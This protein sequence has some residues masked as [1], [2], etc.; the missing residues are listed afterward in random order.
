V[1][2]LFQASA[3]GYTH[4]VWN[5]T[6]PWWEFIVRGAIVYVFLIVLLRLTGKR[7]VGQLAPFDLVLLL[8]LSNAV[9]NSNRLARSTQATLRGRQQDR[10]QRIPPH[11]RPGRVTIGAPGFGILVNSNRQEA[12]KDSASLGRRCGDGRIAASVVV[13]RQ[14]PISRVLPFVRKNLGI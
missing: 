11:R 12:P 4:A 7:Q 2:R 10:R 8:V 13:N 5:L 14:R 1:R 3:G 9:Q 6:I